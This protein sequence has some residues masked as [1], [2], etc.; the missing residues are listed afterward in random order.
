MAINNISSVNQ[1]YINNAQAQN[2]Q[3]NNAKPTQ[4]K[5]GKKMLAIG[6][7]AVAATAIAGVLLYK[8]GVINFKSSAKKSVKTLSDIK[9]EGELGNKKA[10]LKE[11]G[12]KFT[13]QIQHELKDGSNVTIKYKNGMLSESL[14]TSNTG[15]S[16]VIKKHIYEP[17]GDHIVRQGTVALLQD[18]KDGITRMEKTTNLTQQKKFVQNALEEPL[19]L[20]LTNAQ[21]DTALTLFIN[22]SQVGYKEHRFKDGYNDF[23]GGFLYEKKDGPKVKPEPHGYWDIKVKNPEKDYISSF[24]AFSTNG[25]MT[26]TQKA[27]FALDMQDLAESSHSPLGKA[28]KKISEKEAFDMISNWSK[29]INLNDPKTRIALATIESVPECKICGNA[30]VGDLLRE[31]PF[32]K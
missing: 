12:K 15:A 30:K 9:F 27:L 4:V 11:N 20:D 16:A 5:N 32:N 14:Q 31:L 23:T 28:Y 22:N 26:D 3:T 29:D 8:K 1:A 6:A 18:G 13:G 19:K 10:I 2:Q 25:K 24:W 7:A 17:N 21:N